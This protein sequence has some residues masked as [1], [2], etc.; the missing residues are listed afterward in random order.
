MV[1]GNYEASRTLR[2]S[3]SAMLNR[4]ERRAAVDTFAL[5][6]VAE[7]YSLSPSWTPGGPDSPHSLS[8][9]AA[10]QRSETEA[11]ILAPF[12]S[13]SFTAGLGYQYRASEAVTMGLSPSLVSAEQDGQS[14][15]LFT[16]NGTANYRPRGAPYSLN[17]SSGIGQSLVGFQVQAVGSARYQIPRVGTANLRLRATGFFGDLDYREFALSFG[18]AR[19]F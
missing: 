8:L 17:F 19:S 4:L 13:H 15:N 2:F 9:N 3:A 14:E 1:A 16:L 5:V 12:G 7:S 10:L 18:L 11:G 6:N